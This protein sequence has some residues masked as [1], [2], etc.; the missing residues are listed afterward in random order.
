MSTLTR[1]GAILEA[2]RMLDKGNFDEASIPSFKNIMKK[3]GGKIG[4][5]GLELKDHGLAYEGSYGFFINLIKELGYE[6]DIGIKDHY[7][8]SNYSNRDFAI[9]AQMT[10]VGQASSSAKVSGESFSITFVPLK[11]TFGKENPHEREKFS[12]WFYLADIDSL[13]DLYKVLTGKDKRTS[14]WTKP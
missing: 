3:I 5:D 4:Y 8:F 1:V 13:E 11:T 12:F 2:Y 9:N 10:S 14:K 6:A 7:S